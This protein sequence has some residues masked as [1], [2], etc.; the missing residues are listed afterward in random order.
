MRLRSNICCKSLH[1]WIPRNTYRAAVLWPLLCL[2]CGPLCWAEEVD[3]L[4]AAVN[5]RVI[6][7][8][9]VK[10]AGDLNAL[11]VLGISAGM[12]SREEEVE[13][14]IDLALL[15]EELENFA[16]APAEHSKVELQ[17]EELRLAYAEIGGLSY[18][19]RRLGL[20]EAELRTYLALQ[21]SILKFV[22]L[23]FRPFVSV[24]EDEVKAYYQ[25][26]LIPSLQRERT[27]IPALAEVGSRIE[28][29]LREEK[30]NAALEAWIQEIRRH[31]RIERFVLRDRA[32]AK[33]TP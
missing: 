11:V 3:R 23:R 5:G 29:L 30:V 8:G 16:S 19:L 6:T 28:K 1:D 20:Q 9:D 15:R 2:L 12:T 7:E 18:L 33:K 4:L 17:L 10:V 25:E 22:D 26:R 31:S 21:A 13:R 27:P 24:T 32:E 14:L